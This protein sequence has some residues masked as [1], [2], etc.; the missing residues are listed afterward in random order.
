M[1]QL[2]ISPAGDAGLSTD[3]YS[4]GTV[5]PQFQSCERQDPAA[6][7]HVYQGSTGS[8]FK[9][10]QHE[11]EAQLSGGM[12]GRE[13]SSGF[14]KNPCRGFRNQ[15]APP[16][17]TNCQRAIDAVAEKHNVTSLQKLLVVFD[18]FVDQPPTSGTGIGKAD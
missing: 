9:V 12:V 11:A 1:V 14:Q 16:G 15:K 13:G 4:H 7:A 5:H 17:S 2:G 6:A 10:L 3:I 18:V 8:S